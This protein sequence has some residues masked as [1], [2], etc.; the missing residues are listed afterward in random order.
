MVIIRKIKGYLKWYIYPFLYFLVTS[1]VCLFAWN[2]RPVSHRAGI[3]VIFKTVSIVPAVIWS[4][5]ITLWILFV[6]FF[7]VFLFRLKKRFPSF[8]TLGGPADIKV[9][10]EMAST[11]KEDKDGKSGWRRIADRS[12]Y[13]LG[14]VLISGGLTFGMWIAR[15]YITLLLFSSKVE[16]LEKKVQLQQVQGDRIIIPSLLVD[17]PIL[18]GVSKGQ[19]LRGVCH[20][21]SSPLPGQRGNC[22]IEGHNLAEFGLWKPKSFFSL[23]DIVSEGTLIYVFHNGNQYAYKVKVKTYR[24]VADLTLYDATPGERLTLITCVS[25]WSPTIYT[26]RRTMVIAYPTF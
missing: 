20:V 26:N 21:S 19:L 23:L 5:V 18:E 24:D 13:F 9:S 15:P 17:A 25:T 14:I 2:S 4:G 1:L 7:A 10:G 12:F 11:T 16:A 3:E 6:I 8:M 22:I